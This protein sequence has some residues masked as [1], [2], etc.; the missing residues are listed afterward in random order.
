METE[1]IR[2]QDFLASLG[3]YPVYEKG[4]YAEY[5]TSPALSEAL[6]KYYIRTVIFKGQL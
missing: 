5:A 4:D 3:I 6:D 2:L 1:D